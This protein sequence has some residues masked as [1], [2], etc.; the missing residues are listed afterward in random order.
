MKLGDGPTLEAVGQGTIIVHIKFGQHTR[1]CTLYEVLYIPNF[2]YNIISVSKATKRGI[3]FKFNDSSC[4]IQDCNDKGITVASRVGGLYEISIIP[5]Q[6]HSAMHNVCFTTEDLWHY[7]YGHLSMKN[8]QKL[9]RDE[10]VEGFNY[11]HSKEI[12]FCESC[13]AG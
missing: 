12:Q 11:S 6:I 5:H 3:S 13:V 4:I 8:L 7:R 2:A 9:A 1:K 10:L